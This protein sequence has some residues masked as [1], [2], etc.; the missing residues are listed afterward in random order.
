LTYQQNFQNQINPSN[1][2]YSKQYYKL[3]MI[4]Y[5]TL[6]S[7]GLQTLNSLCISLSQ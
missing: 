4:D 3:Y 2:L 1:K 6:W 5:G 7:C